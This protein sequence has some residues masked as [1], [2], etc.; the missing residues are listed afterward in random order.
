MAMHPEIIFL[1]SSDITGS[2][3]F[4]MSEIALLAALERL[5]PI[6]PAS[7]RRLTRVQCIQFLDPDPL[8]TLQRIAKEHGG[9]EGFINITREDLGLDPR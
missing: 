5:N 4:E 9:A 8:G 7:N 3:E 2:G 6:D 1:L